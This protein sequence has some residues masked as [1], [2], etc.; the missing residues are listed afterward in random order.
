MVNWLPAWQSIAKAS[1]KKVES[2]AIDIGQATEPYIMRQSDA[3]LFRRQRHK[4]KPVKLTVDCEISMNSEYQPAIDRTRANTFNTL[5]QIQKKLKQALLSINSFMKT[6]HQIRVCPTFPY[7]PR[8]VKSSTSSP[9]TKRP[10]QI[11]SSR[12]HRPPPQLQLASRRH[13]RIHPDLLS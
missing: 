7:L 1:A 2:L 3:S 6:S 13:P 5:R 12:H 8:L 11:Q 10:C 9:T 4:R